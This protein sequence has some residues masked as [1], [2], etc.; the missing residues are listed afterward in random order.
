MENVDKKIIDDAL[1]LCLEILRDKKSGLL[2]LVRYISMEKKAN[3]GIFDSDNSF[4]Y[5]QTE[6][7]FFLEELGIFQIFSTNQEYKFSNKERGFYTVYVDFNKMKV[8]V[9]RILSQRLKTQVK[10][11]SKNFIA[12]LSGRDYLYEAGILYLK[13]QNKAHDVLDLSKANTLRP[14]FESFYFLFRDIN[15]KLFT[16]E[17]LLGKYKEI[18]G[19][20]I[21]WR[22]FISRKST[23]VGKLI[24]PKPT[25]RN[26]IIWRFDKK[27]E[28]YHFEILSLSV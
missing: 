1:Q 5:H 27:T 28:K 13:L 18:T 4:L 10:E 25:L 9:D 7:P 12:L 21:E 6:T 17:E 22:R 16:R 2:S 19:D 15:K 20:E 24:N 14:V 11:D 8:W 3:W 23:V 26:R